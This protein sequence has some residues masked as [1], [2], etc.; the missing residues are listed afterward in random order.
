MFYYQSACSRN[1]TIETRNKKIE[2]LNRKSETGD[3]GL[4]MRNEHLKF[5]KIFNDL[6]L[7][8]GVKRCKNR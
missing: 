2:T 8:K 3:L 1:W 7:R 4:K 6:L 5:K